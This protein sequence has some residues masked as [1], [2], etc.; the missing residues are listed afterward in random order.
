MT[1]KSNKTD[2][3][4]HE[5]ANIHSI[6]SS[7]FRSSNLQ[8]I[9]G[10]LKA[11]ESNTE[12]QKHRDY[13]SLFAKTEATGP[14]DHDSS[15]LSPA[16]YFVDLMRLIKTTV[17]N[18]PSGLSLEERRPD[19]LEIEL[20]AKNTTTEVPYLEIVNDILAKNLKAD[21]GEDKLQQLATSI[22]PFNLPYNAPL[23]RIRIYLA[24]FSVKL[25]DIY[26][27]LG[28]PE[29]NDAWVAETLGLSSPEWERLMRREP[30]DAAELCKVYGFSGI[31]SGMQI[32]GIDVV[33]TF[34]K[35]TGLTPDELTELRVMDVSLVGSL[36]DGLPG[37]RIDGLDIE[38]LDCLSRF[39]RLAKRL[40][41]SFSDLHWALRSLGADPEDASWMVL[42]YVYTLPDLAKIK[43]ISDKY[44]LAVDL[45][46][47]FV[48]D[49]N[50]N[51]GF[52]APNQPVPKSLFDRVFNTPSFYQGE[53]SEGGAYHPKGAGFPKSKTAGLLWNT[54]RQD[55]K[56][57][58]IRSSLLVALTV[59]NDDLQAIV[60]HM[61]NEKLF[62]A[63]DHLDATA[64]PLDLHTL[65]RLY[66]F[67]KMASVLEMR[68]PEYL[69][70]LG[71][72]TSKQQVEHR[73][74]I[75]EVTS[76]VDLS[77]VD[78]W[79]DWLKEAQLSPHQ[80]EYLTTGEM[81]HEARRSIAPGWGDDSL[82][83]LTS[84]LKTT[85]KPRRVNEQAFVQGTIS[86]EESAAAFNALLKT[87]LIVGEGLV[88]C[89]VAE[90]GGEPG[91][92]PQINQAQ[93]RDAVGDVTASG[94]L[95]QSLDSDEVINTITDTLNRELDFQMQSTI[96]QLATT[97]NSHWSEVAGTVDY[98]NWKERGAAKF[99]THDGLRDAGLLLYLA[100]MLKLSSDGFDTVLK[101]PSLFGFDSFR[102]N[103]RINLDTIRSV[104]AFAGLVESF[105]QQGSKGKE[106]APLLAE[107][108]L[109]W[110]FDELAD[111]DSEM[112]STLSG[113]QES[114]IKGLQ[115]YLNTMS[116]PSDRMAGLATIN[117]SLDLAA[118]LGVDVQMLI[119]LCTLHNPQTT[120][121][122][123]SAVAHSLLGV[124]KSKYGDNDWEKTFSPIRDQL[125]ERE[126]DALVGLL[127]HQLSQNKN[128]AKYFDG[129]DTLQDL[130]DYLLIDVEMS[131]VAKV[132]KVK[133]GLNTLQ[134]YIQRCHMGL[135]GAVTFPLGDKEWAWR[136]HYRLW[137][138]NRKVFL[139]PENYL[140]PGLR[141]IKTPLYQEL[142]DEL[143]QGE[144]TDEA[145]TRAYINY[146]DKLDELASLEIV[147]ACAAKVTHPGA[148][149]G[150]QTLFI[151]GKTKNDPPA[152][153]YRSA[154]L[155]NNWQI[156]QW[157]PWQKI[158]LSIHVDSVSCLYA[159]H[160]LHL[161]WVEQKHSSERA[162]ITD[163]KTTTTKA[164]VKFS[165]HDVSGNWVPPQFLPGF[166]GVI[167][168]EVEDQKST[169][170]FLGMSSPFPPGKPVANL[171]LSKAAERAGA[172]PRAIVSFRCP[173]SQDAAKKVAV[174]LLLKAGVVGAII[175]IDEDS[176]TDFE[177]FTPSSD[178]LNNFDVHSLAVSPDGRSLFAGTKSDGVY[179][180]EDHGETWVK[181]DGL[182]TQ[183]VNSLA[184]SPDGRS[185]FAGTTNDGVYRSE[186]HGETWVKKNTS[187]VGLDS[188][189]K[190]NS[191]AV[192]PDGRSLFAGTTDDGVYRSENHGE[193]WV[194]KADGLKTHTINSLAVSPDGRT[195][196]A[197][198]NS[199]GVFRSE[200][201]GETWVKADGL[202]DLTVFALAVSP[203]GQFLFA[204]TTNNGVIRSK[205]H[206]ETWVRHGEM[207][208][209]VKFIAVSP[210]GRFLFAGNELDGVFRSEV[211]GETWVK[212]DG[213]TDLYVSALAVSPDGQSLFAGTTND[214]V[215]RSE[216]KRPCSFNVM[217]TAG[218]STQTML[219]VT[220]SDYLM[221]CCY[222]L[223]RLGSHAVNELR[224]KLVTGGV[225]ELMSLA[226]QKTAESPSLT[227]MVLTKPCPEAFLDFQ[228]SSAYAIYYREIFFHIPFLIAD[229][230]NHNQHFED[231]QTWY[232]HIFNPMAAPD[233]CRAPD[234]A[235]YWSYRPFR[236]HTLEKLEEFA[237]NPQELKV[238][239]DDPFDP[240][241]IAALRLG[242]Y[243]KA[244]VMKY[245]DNLLDWGDQ[246][247]AQDSW[248][249][250]VQAMM[251]YVMAQDLLG[252]KPKQTQPTHSPKLI[253]L[254]DLVGKKI[255]LADPF[256]VE[257]TLYFPVAPN[258][259]FAGYWD[260]ADDRLFKIRHSMNIKGVVRQLALFQPPI[261]PRQLIR[262]MAAGGDINRVTSQLAAPMPHY[263]FSTMI[264]QAKS[265]TSTLTQLGSVLLSALEKKDAEQL[266]LLRSTHEKTIL[267]LT[268][269]LKVKQIED[270][271]KNLDS[272]N[273]SLD[274]ATDR[275]KHYQKLS[276]D[277]LSAE[278]IAGINLMISA[279]AFQ[280][281]SVPIRGLSVA[282]HLAPNIFGLADGGSKWG[283][284][285]TVGAQV[286]EG[287]AAT[288]NQGSQLATTKA[289]NERRK[290]E[291]QLQENLAGHDIEQIKAQI[292]SAKIKQ[293]VAQ[294]DLDM[295]QKSIEQANERED[296]LRGKFTNRELYQWM[297]GRISS[298][299]FQTYKIAF[300][301]AQAAEKSYQ[302]E[303]NTDDTLITF[304]YWDSLKKGMLAGEGL[305][306]GLNQLEKAYMEDNERTLEIEKTISLRQMDPQA[307][308][309]LRNGETCTFELSEALFDRD[310]PGHYCRKI[311][312]IAITIPAIVGPYQNVQATLTQQ[313]S[314]VVLTNNIDT[315]KYLLPADT[316]D[317]TLRSA[318]SDDQLRSDWRDK[319]QIALSKGINDN[320][321][322]ELNFHDERYLPFEGTGAVSSWELRM[323]K[324]TNRIDFDS[325]SD[326]IIHLRYTALDGGAS[327]R[328]NVEKLIKKTRA[329]D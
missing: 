222:G 188:P 36:E 40:G 322:F 208:G 113:W 25:A 142:E 75:P 233:T 266:N 27:T 181:A 192:S 30:Y 71:C 215:Y 234:G 101:T 145:V 250:I 92:I 80:L 52:A 119:Q 186:D 237:E 284:A 325:I 214:G 2:L 44:T 121:E 190:V 189:S 73:L 79:A 90:A 316:N 47:S 281:A 19:L 164:T 321:M 241:A 251:L 176:R 18:V 245:I 6:A 46:C 32:G 235:S 307:W 136:S 84:E 95:M 28:L 293:E 22:Y 240:H 155:D 120:F 57:Q 97:F 85:L 243:E 299:Y 283:S 87:G 285:I 263:R 318:P 213:L 201:H 43:K 297:V 160:R 128:I 5:W 130:S 231:A 300:E 256:H 156:N 103:I 108:A 93:V 17:K 274:S 132:S 72:I 88:Q 58:G 7:D 279:L 328:Q 232:H 305:M 287:I 49:M 110:S 59:G 184:V 48:H 244:I 77:T 301:L 45:V 326:V 139:Y 141:K 260:R 78:Y 203:D 135:E 200:D 127:M 104:H 168:D 20:D 131:G 236:G 280:T 29:D 65:T 122:E 171:I 261:D 112:L 154:V 81:T 37:D 308:L 11:K 212:V 53:E 309:K 223:Y 320:G 143:L 10:E 199:D 60:D 230:L 313:T 13:Q 8:E 276:D 187:F 292:E 62:T 82:K 146:F 286:S 205:D 174:D 1:D 94:A 16:A 26:E 282:G 253:N 167:I 109:H 258:T 41:W 64:I 144:I 118:K 153:Y 89:P 295:H 55:P 133:Q 262:A 303:H 175:S 129:M 169:F 211:H 206:G 23:E 216:D 191:L 150:E 63:A 69:A 4:I 67:S 277:G 246:L 68:V 249:S 289:Q 324:A 314:R 202:T 267:K 123:L 158:N 252:K 228:L 35:Q 3:T 327:L 86:S 185:L 161:F 96:Q 270:A 173:N 193:T 39:I 291:W 207:N 56:S 264:Q 290:E 9:R 242:A 248:E 224:G 179:R 31:K 221:T 194:K 227:S 210:D 12:S 157:R 182:T 180:S 298:V 304:G 114:Q 147:D 268:T 288:L 296:L 148:L 51:P 125:N 102:S 163:K 76:V 15:I 172:Q 198:T 91:K 220:F 177:A 54:K 166:E 137:E 209:S 152:Y 107:L 229:T 196:F 162:E 105:Q 165:Y 315:I 312:S 271:S 99:L 275:K 138:A 116:R 50:T 178:G 24:H 254:P 311:A 140:D 117:R 170:D 111:S 197:G 151:I 278:E 100:K 126:R 66:R 38:R 115:G 134:R 302:Y 226:S 149:D 219:L 319:Q 34:L 273:A 21:T 217:E 218:A 269:R 195:L 106:T 61:C 98:L 323:P 225:K 238:Y 183:N 124:V 204:S 14:V 239:E 83:Q 329:F 257:D 255:D 294:M 272:M 33:E 70:L 42:V 259:N 310:F 265:V 306:L 74:K 159:N 247:F 317:T